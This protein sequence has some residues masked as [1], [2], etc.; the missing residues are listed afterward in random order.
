[1]IP[2]CWTFAA[3]MEYM[4]EQIAQFSEGEDSSYFAVSAED[5]DF[6]QREVDPIYTTKTSIGRDAPRH[7]DK[8]LRLLLAS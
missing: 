8:I 6:L 7:F 1:M 4:R 5:I 2:G 3:F